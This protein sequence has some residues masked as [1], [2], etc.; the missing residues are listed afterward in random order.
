MSMP[1]KT[2]SCTQ[3]DFGKSDTILWGKF[4]YRFPDGETLALDRTFG[5]CNSCTDIKAVEELPDR[6]CANYDLRCVESDLEEE[7]YIKKQTGLWSSFTQWWSKA[8]LE[9]E[10]QYKLDA[11][12]TKKEQYLLQLR[13]LDGRN[14]PPRCLE[15]SSTYIVQLAELRS[16]N[17]S[18]FKHPGCGGTFKQTTEYSD[19]RVS[20]ELEEIIC[21]PEGVRLG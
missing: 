7:L 10:R 5:W 11:L 18:S 13:L 15:C 9:R 19:T 14:S 12:T 17:A 3:C 21:D 20:I 8:R 16:A 1:F 2:L 6:I 4:S